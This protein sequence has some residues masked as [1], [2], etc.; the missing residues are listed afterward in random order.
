MTD[1]LQEHDCD[2]CRAGIARYDV[3]AVTRQRCEEDCA[4]LRRI[5]AGLIQHRLYLEGSQFKSINAANQM[6]RSL[7]AGEGKAHVI[8]LRMRVRL[9]LEDEAA[10]FD[11]WDI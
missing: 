10:P 5:E 8:R 2:W 3:D 4:E 11:P 1:I 9:G 7:K 6:R